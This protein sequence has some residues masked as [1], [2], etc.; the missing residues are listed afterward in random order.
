MSRSIPALVAAVAAVLGAPPPAAASGRL[1]S[2]GAALRCA[3]AHA[4][5][6]VEGDVA[7]TVVT[8]VFVNDLDAPVEASYGFP[9]PEDAA[10]TGFAD[11]RQGRRIEASIAGREEASEAY[12]AAADEGR[13]AALTETDRRAGFVL[14]LSAIAPRATRRVELSYVQTLSG[15]GGERTYVFPAGQ[16]PAATLTDVEVHLPGERPMRDLRSL[17]HPDARVDRSPPGGAA[18]YASRG[19]GGLG[20]DLVLRWRE[21]SAPLDLA[22]RAVRA[23]SSEPGYVEA[24]FAF[25]ADPAGHLQ[26]P[27]D[28]VLLVDTSLSMA[29]EPLERARVL[30]EGVLSELRTQDRVELVSFA[31]L[32][33]M[34]FGELVAADDVALHRGLERLDDLRARGRSNLEAALAT[35]EDLL[36]GSERGLLVLVTDGQ[37]TRGAGFAAVELAVDRAAFEGTRVVWAHVSYPSRQ[38]GIEA[39]FPNITTRYL[40]DG[41]AGEEA[42]EELIRLAVA[43]SIEALDVRLLGVGVGEVVGVVPERLAVGEHVRLLARADSQVVVMVTGMLHGRPLLMQ[44]I[45]VAPDAPDG[46]GDRGLPV[47]WARLRVRDLEARLGSLDGAAAEAIEAEV[48]RLGTTYGLATR[49][50][51]YVLADTLAPDRFKPGDPEIRVHAPRQALGVRAILPW[52]EEIRCLWDEDEELWLGRFLVP[53]GVADGTYRMRVFVDSQAGTALRGTLFFRVDSLPPA[54]ALEVEGEGPWSSGSVV[55]VVAR[56]LD[57]VFEGEVVATT[58]DTVV[59]DRIDLRRISVRV[60]ARDVPLAQSGLGE[61]WA[62]EVA[63]DLPAGRHTLRLVAVDYAANATEAELVVEVTP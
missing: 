22:A 53:R 23:V 49:F 30:A 56:P 13:P 37:P 40:P 28:V 26:P 9:L 21:I 60:G 44:Q 14:K 43:P 46:R 8:Q 20:H 52:G 32:V 55:R 35:A 6:R 41:P 29:G 39:L 7:R 58:G 51:S 10:V 15:L 59:R 38:G 45:V 12:E 1:A 42:V 63:L 16:E 47:E 54:F 33:T 48:R 34:T 57:G 5:V 36:R 2:G 31:D 27:R 62:A 19:R 17:N 18:V 11:W 61:V 50:T 24:R 3:Y 4:E 25:S